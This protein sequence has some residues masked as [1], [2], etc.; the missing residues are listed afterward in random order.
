MREADL[1]RFGG[2]SIHGFQVR[3]LLLFL[4][5]GIAVASVMLLTSLGEGARRYVVQE[6]T[7]LGSHLLVVLPGRSETTGGAPPLFGATPRDL[8]LEDAM[9][10]YRSSAVRYVAPISVGSAPVSRGAREREVTILGSNHLLYTIRHLKMGQGRFIPETEP[11]RALNVCVLGSRVKEELFGRSSALGE[12]VRIN[13]RR[14]RVIGILADMGQSLGANIRDSVVIPVASAQQLFNTRGLFRIL[15]QAKGREMLE[16]AGDDIRDIIRD[17]H[18]GEDDVT[19][20]TQDAL[21]STFDRIF[22]ALTLT[23][24]GIAAISLAVAG[25]LIMNVMLVSVSQRT[26]E[27]GLLKAVGASRRQIQA[28]FLTEA[29]ML[30]LIGAALGV[31]VALLGVE[32]LQRLYPE[33]PV[34]IPPW[35]LLAA[36]GVAVIT[37]I[38]FGI[39]PARRASRLDPVLALSRR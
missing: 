16:K 14:Y 30:S 5:M 6:F 27:V 37:G 17:R 10:L 20:I 31:A 28:I 7:A 15:I 26:A 39:L 35:A 13:D 29:A 36:V 32:V 12:W 24:G 18:D 11:G 1:V 22:Q 23:V 25:I 9:A 4:A 33:F 19:V 38:V 21:L 2:R 8:T 34:Q 3:S